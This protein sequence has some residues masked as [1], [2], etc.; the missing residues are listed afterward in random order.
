[1]GIP[2]VVDK[3]MYNINGETVIGISGVMNVRGLKIRGV[4]DAFGNI[5]DFKKSGFIFGWDNHLNKILENITP[6]MFSLVI[7]KKLDE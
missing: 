5:L 6:Q 1:M 2:V 7:A 3:V 4:W